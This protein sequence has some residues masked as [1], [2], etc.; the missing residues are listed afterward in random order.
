MSNKKKGGGGDDEDLVQAIVIADS[1]NRHFTPI[2]YETPR[3]LLPLAN[4]VV[5]DYTIEYLL[6]E[7]VHEVIVFCCSFAEKIRTYITKK[8]C[9]E[10]SKFNIH[11]VMSSAT[12]CLCLGDALREIDREGLIRNDFILVHGDLVSNVQLSAAIKEHKERRVNKKEKELVM[13]MLHRKV[14]PGHVNRTADDDVYIILEK[15]TNRILHYQKSREL[16][17]LV[18]P[19][20]LLANRKEINIHYNLVDCNVYIC[21]PQFAPLFTDNFDYQTL[22]DFV[23]GVLI[24]EDILGDKIH[25]CIVSQGY[26]SRVHDLPMYNF[27]SLDLLNRW[28]YPL[29]PDHTT[30]TYKRNNVYVGDDVTIELDCNISDGVM[31]G[32]GSTV[33]TETCISRSVIG[34]NCTIGANVSIQNSFI[35]DNCIVED[36]ARIVHTVMCTN[37]EVK[38]NACVI[39]SIVSYNVCVG[40][41]IDIP[42]RTRLSLLRREHIAAQMDGLS[43]NGRENIAYDKSVVGESGKGFAWEFD[44]DEEEVVPSLIATTCADASEDESS[45]EEDDD[46]LPP[47]PPVEYTN[48]EQFHMEVVENLRSGIAENIAPDNIALEINAS[49]FKYNTSI[50]DLCQTVVKAMLEL[51]LGDET[52]SKQ[53]LVKELTRTMASLHKVLLK[54]FGNVDEQIHAVTAAE[55]FFSSRLEMGAVLATYLHKMYDADLLDENIILK[56]YATKAADEERE[57]LRNNPNLVKLI[58]WLQEAEEEESDDDEDSD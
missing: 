26:S 18:F 35:W 7:G 4:K 12:D 45:D 48:L 29:V 53:E 55:D 54:Y 43:L 17:K 38:R 52:R 1:F 11:C 58:T 27:I 9:Y 8:W 23:R 51:A 33:G 32:A 47:S 25:S 37:A 36:G 57:E 21:S 14:T 28:I 30:H 56:W 10:G 49:K 40:D 50:T 15:E 46:S 34:A 22:D 5:I 13:T 31:I 19:T 16:P 42:E 6:E 39:N 2:T 41:G 20:S 3:A 24:N 44:P